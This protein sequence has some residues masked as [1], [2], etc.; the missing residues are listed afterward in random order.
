VKTIILEASD[1]PGVL[2]SHVKAE[3]P[4]AKAGLVRGDIILEVDGV[5]VDNPKELF[6][7]LQDW[8]PGD[9]VELKV[10]HG[11]E[12]RI[13]SVTPED[14][15][16]SPDLGLELRDGLPE[17]LF[18]FQSG[19]L[20]GVIV[21]EV[22]PDSPAEAAGL[23]PGDQILAVDGE[24]V[25]PDKSLADL[26]GSHQPGDTVTLSIARP[27]EEERTV[28]V[29]LEE[30]PDQAGQAY[31]GIFYRPGRLLRD[32][33]RLPDFF[34]QPKFDGEH[35]QLPE[36]PEGID[37]AAVI[38]QVLAESPAAAAGLQSGDFITAV[39]EQPL[40]EA[41]SLSRAIRSHQPGEKVVLTVIRTGEAA[42]QVNVTL[43]E[44]PEQAG[45]AYLGVRT[46]FLHIQRDEAESQSGGETFW[47][48]P[49]PKLFAAL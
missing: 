14:Q 29:K 38:S 15:N 33:D 18:A 37:R 48:I 41:G 5:A 22:T 8:S 17:S 34:L 9:P 46:G 42:R 1:G 20:N 40:E 2:V 39:N 36:L 28:T 49:L 21:T 31:L 30:D 27:G 16:G 26:I 23:K 19:L 4:A 12:Q 13:L 11:D 7:A 45:Q 10:Q 25:G 6:Q 3:G 44:D 35:F 47:N 32:R 43:G 24:E